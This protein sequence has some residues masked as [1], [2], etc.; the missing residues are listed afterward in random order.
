MNMLKL[1]FFGILLT[2]LVV[3]THASIEEAIWK[4]PEI[5]QRDVWFQATMFDAY[6]GFLTFYLWVFYR[7]PH[8]V[9]RILWFIAI[10]LLGNMAMAVYMLMRL[11]KLKPGQGLP[12]LLLRD[13]SQI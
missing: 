10:M 1:I 9:A 2:M 12:H 11:Y 6:F 7:S 8:W 13:P 4:V 5:V 3:T